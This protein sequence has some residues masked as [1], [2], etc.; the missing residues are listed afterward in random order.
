MRRHGAFSEHRTVEFGFVMEAL[1]SLDDPTILKRCADPTSTAELVPLEVKSMTSLYVVCID[2][3]PHS[4]A[5]S[6]FSALTSVRRA[7][8]T[9]VFNAP[10]SAV[11]PTSSPK[12]FWEAITQQGN[13]RFEKKPGSKDGS[14]GSSH[15]FQTLCVVPNKTWDRLSH[16]QEKR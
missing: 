16:L 7:R 8:A 11:P 1:G 14:V 12:G 10:I 9:A 2:C 3:R 6:A 5:T 15:L 4:V 13:R